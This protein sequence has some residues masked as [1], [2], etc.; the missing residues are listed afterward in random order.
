MLHDSAP[1]QNFTSNLPQ[2][3]PWSLIFYYHWLIPLGLTYRA[4]EKEKQY[5][6]R[7]N[8]SLIDLTNYS[9]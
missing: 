2:V 3:F 9:K 7:D 1:I 8:L 4:A 5:Q 6:S